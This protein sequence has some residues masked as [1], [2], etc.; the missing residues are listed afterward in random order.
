MSR[1]L[2]SIIIN[3]YNYASF[4]KEAINSALSQTY[5]LTEVVVV[6]DGSTDNSRDLISS[7]GNAVTPIFKENGGQASALNAGVLASRGEILCFLDSDDYFYPEKV[8]EVV[9]VFIAQQVNSKPMMLHHRVAAKNRVGDDIVGRLADDM[10]AR[11]VRDM[12]ECPTN[13]YS[14]AKRFHFIPYIAGPTSSLSI[15]RMLANKLFPVPEKGI[16][17]SADDF[18]VYGSSLIADVYA[19]DRVL[20]VYRVHD[21][22][23]WYHSIRQKSPEFQHILNDYLNNK[24]VESGMCPTISFY[25]S[26]FAWRTFVAERQWANLASCMLKVSLKQH[27][28]I[29]AREVYYVINSIIRYVIKSIIK[30]SLLHKRLFVFTL[31][32]TKSSSLD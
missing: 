6:D 11:L 17:I 4:L 26:M 10:V 16:R 30:M 1:P 22:N 31:S 2:V 13:L 24:L 3:N 7:Y 8:A 28:F 12:Q 25:D 32:Q 20:G 23:N 21:G 15:N 18:I 5:L 9:E 27:D 19:M 29:A 14:F